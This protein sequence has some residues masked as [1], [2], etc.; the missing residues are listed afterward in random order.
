VYSIFCCHKK[1]SNK[2]ENMNQEKP[3]CAYCG[4]FVSYD[5][6]SYTP[7][8]CSSYDPPEPYD[9]EYVCSKHSEELYADFIRQFKQG[10]RYGDWQ[11][12]RAEIRAAKDCGLAWVGGDGVGTFG[13]S[14]FAHGYEYIT[15][16]EFDRL[17][18]LPYWGYCKI[19]G[20]ERK[21]GYCSNV[22]CEMSFD[23]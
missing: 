19:C 5:A 6:D 21:N 7:Y 23:R 16:E 3:R 8:G 18:A 15:Q 2:N 11:K 13:T 4:V 10:S 14:D 9:P 22:A 20:A 17:S 1:P 12:S